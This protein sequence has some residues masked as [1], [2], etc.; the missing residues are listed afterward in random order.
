MA[1]MTCAST[2][3]AFCTTRVG[4]TSP[5]R[6][7]R[8][9]ASIS[10]A[11]SRNVGTNTP[12][13]TASSECPARPTRCSPFATRLGDW[14]W[15]TRSTD[16]MSIPSSSELVLIE[17]AQRAGLERLLERQPPLARQR[18]VI[19]QRELLAGER[20]DAR[21]HLLGL[22]AIVDE[23]ERRAR[24]AHVLEHQRRDRRP[25]RS[26]DVREIF[27]RRL[28][29]QSSCFDEA[30]VDDRAVRAAVL[31]LVAG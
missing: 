3:S 11:S 10:I 17:R 5:S 30:A 28:D 8:T 7:A 25:D 4:S 23:H 19:R 12:R 31:A 15:S 6:I 22:R 16:P 14:S 1:T 9:T 13:L 24:G 18:A 21:R 26:A 20:V 29:R 27:D 2:S